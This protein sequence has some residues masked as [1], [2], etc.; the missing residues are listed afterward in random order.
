MHASVLPEFNP[1][2][3]TRCAKWLITCRLEQDKTVRSRNVACA[4]CKVKHS[5][6]YF[7]PSDRNFEYRGL[8][9]GLLNLRNV[10]PEERYCMKW[11]VSAMIGEQKILPESA[12]P[13]GFHLPPQ[14][15]KRYQQLTCMHCYKKVSPVDMRPTGCLDC[16]CDV[17]P[18]RYIYRLQRVGSAPDNYC[19]SIQKSAFHCGETAMETF[20][21]T[22]FGK[23][24]CTCGRHGDW[25]G[26]ECGR[27]RFPEKV[28]VLLV[29]TFNIC[30]FYSS[31]EGPYGVF[32][33]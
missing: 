1:N 29:G 8:G 3:L 2:L 13:W 4:F 5:D 7:S 24:G 17:C 21:F 22:L 18:R 32:G 19:T 23:G 15:W 6:E 25:R 11:I 26:C 9:V 20:F 12:V 31:A 33:S 14:A 10:H 16:L 30:V 27:R 28:G